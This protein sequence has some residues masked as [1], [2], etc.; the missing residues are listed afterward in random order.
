MVYKDELESRKEREPKSID[1]LPYRKVILIVD[2][3]NP[4]RT[5]IAISLKAK[6][7]AILE[8]SNGSDALE[9]WEVHR[10]PID[11]MITDQKMPLMTGSELISRVATVMPT[12][13]IM[14]LSGSDRR[15]AQLPVNVHILQK[16]FTLKGLI[17]NVQDI[18][19]DGTP[20]CA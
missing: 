8:A 2:D 17:S 19:S 5:L 11:L 13:K 14:C 15:P 4:V 20:K 1:P 7:Y 18:L 12:M 9:L 6:G 16:P 10:G 3:E